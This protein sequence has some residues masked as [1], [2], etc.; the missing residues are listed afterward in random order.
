MFSVLSKTKYQLSKNWKFLNNSFM[1]LF[2][3]KLITAKLAAYYLYLRHGEKTDPH[4]TLTPLKITK[5]SYSKTVH[6]AFCTY[7]ML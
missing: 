5:Y 1:N 3:M 7:E 2:N 4:E 6:T